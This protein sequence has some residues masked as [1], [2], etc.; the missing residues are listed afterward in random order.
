M[1]LLNKIK[2]HRVI[3]ASGSPRRHELL[4]GLDISFEID[5]TSEVDESY[6]PGMPVHEIAQFIAGQKSHGFHRELK[7]N[8]ILITA[9]TIVSIENQ[10]L[11]KPKDHADALKM[12]RTLS[13][14][15]HIVY[16]G[17]C[18]RTTKEERSF[19]A[20]TGVTFREITDREI[21][22]YVDNYKPYDKAG[23]YGVQEWIGYIAITKIDGS[24]YNVMGLPVQRLYRELGRLLDN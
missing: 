18:I 23:A 13:N 12:L 3:L 22:Y 6:D 15:T 14:K 19:M 2:Q 5:N 9:D 1:D 8:E 16:T 7:E 24:Y 10:V 17:V 11:G 21:K 4:A 20:A